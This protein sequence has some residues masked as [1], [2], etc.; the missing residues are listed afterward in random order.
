MKIIKSLIII[1]LLSACGFT[2]NATK[3]ENGNASANVN[4]SSNASRTI[5]ESA[6]SL[7]N[8]TENSDNLSDFGCVSEEIAVVTSGI[9]DKFDLVSVN[10]VNAWFC[11]GAEF[12]DILLALETEELSGFTADD[13]LQ[14]VAEG[15]TW[16]E[17]WDFVGLTGE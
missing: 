10:Q 16:D 4:G 2:N 17:I 8:V 13:M 12:E 3:I 5:E 14:L 15:Y 1:S 7:P 9:A 11:D 6:T